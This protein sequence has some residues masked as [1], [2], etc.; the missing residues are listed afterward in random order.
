MR[1]MKHRSASEGADFHQEICRVYENDS[2]HG[3]RILKARNYIRK[4]LPQST[5]K[6][7]VE[8]GCGAGDICG[9]FQDEALVMGIDVSEKAIET[10]RERFPN[11]QFSLNRADMMYPMSTG[12]L[13][14]SEF[15]E[16][17]EEPRE[18]V[19]RWAKRCEYMLISHPLNEPLD[20]GL[21]A[22]EHQ[23]S[24]DIGDFHGWFS[25]NNFQ[26]LEE[27]EFAMGSYTCVMGIGRKI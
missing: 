13:V 25:D 14:L 22:G 12:I 9:A 8:L 2:I 10:A 18:L 7:I 16:H 17:L 21:S 6:A 3:E 11:G 15:L 27:Q 4:Y 19:N 23:W 20:S 26:L 1:A 5:A 24:F